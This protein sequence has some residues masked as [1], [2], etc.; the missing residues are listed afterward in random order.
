MDDL[1][2]AKKAVQMNSI[3]DPSFDGSREADLC[4]TLIQCIEDGNGDAFSVAVS[5]FNNI[6]PLGR[7]QSS[8]LVKIKE[9]Y[10]PDGAAP[11]AVANDLDFTGGAGFS[12]QPDTAN[13]DQQ[14]PGGGD[15]DFTW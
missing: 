2:G 12:P 7:S 5:D 9:T 4:Q 1:V 13:T 15:L 3:E 6:T 10:L 8:I 14:Q 11:Q